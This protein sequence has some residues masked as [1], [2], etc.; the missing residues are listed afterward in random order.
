MQEFKITDLLKYPVPDLLQYKV[1]LEFEEHELQQKIN[2]LKV[3]LETFEVNYIYQLRKT[4]SK[5]FITVKDVQIKLSEA[6]LSK[7]HYMLEKEWQKLQNEIFIFKRELTDI[8]SR[9]KAIELI[10]NLKLD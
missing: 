9:I 6:A 1:G 8:Q 7:P 4:A 10:I 3:K 2:Q 5:G